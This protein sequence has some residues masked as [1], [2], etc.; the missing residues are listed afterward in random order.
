MSHLSIVYVVSCIIPAVSETVV[1]SIIKYGSTFYIGIAIVILPY[2]GSMGK[3]K[4][5]GKKSRKA[6]NT[7]CYVL[8]LLLL[9]LL[10]L[11]KEPYLNNPKTNKHENL[12]V[13][14]F[15]PGV[16]TV[17]LYLRYQ[18]KQCTVMETETETNM[19][20]CMY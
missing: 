15:F 3:L 2:F 4:F 20:I 6:R 10:L 17:W 7:D 8:L 13:Y 18:H 1:F 14:I 9:L 11:A 16:C 5:T 12:H 19:K